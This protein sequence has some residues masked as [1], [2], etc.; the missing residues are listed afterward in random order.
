MFGET[1]RAYLPPLRTITELAEELGVTTRSLASRMGRRKPA[2]SYVFRHRKNTWY[3]RE[4]FIKWWE[5][6]GK[7]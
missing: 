3:D 6:V 7:D 5:S 1:V 2:P 4:G